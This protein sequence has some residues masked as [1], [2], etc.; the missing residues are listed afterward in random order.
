MES[1]AAIPDVM[2]QSGHSISGAIL[3]EADS[4]PSTSDETSIA[5]NAP[6]N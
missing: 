3:V 6:A 2:N 4:V 5:K 1:Y